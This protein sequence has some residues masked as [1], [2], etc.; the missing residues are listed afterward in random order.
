MMTVAL[1]G[2][3]AQGEASFIVNEILLVRMQ[4][5]HS[6]DTLSLPFSYGLIGKS[7]TAHSCNV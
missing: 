1:E 4:Y 2:W 3:T 7:M 6:C 5:L